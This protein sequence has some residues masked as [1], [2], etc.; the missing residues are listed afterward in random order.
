VHYSKEEKGIAHNFKQ[1]E[2]NGKEL[3]ATFQSEV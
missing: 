2:D 3:Q 1:K